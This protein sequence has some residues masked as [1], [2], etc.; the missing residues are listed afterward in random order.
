MAGRDRGRMIP[1]PENLRAWS[2][3]ET[4]SEGK[5]LEFGQESGVTRP[6][7]AR[8]RLLGRQGDDRETDSIHRDHAAARRRALCGRRQRGRRVPGR[9]AHRRCARQPRQR[10]RLVP[11]RRSILRRGRDRRRRLSHPGR[12]LSERAGVSARRA[13]ARRVPRRGERSDRGAG[14]G[15]V[16][17]GRERGRLHHTRRSVGERSAARR[18]AARPSRPAS[19]TTPR[20]AAT[21]IGCG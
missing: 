8:I 18:G 6:A 3:Q 12:V 1:E 11:R 5:E 2:Q 19:A 17:P 20:D 9:M 15:A 4:P 10:Q 16:L 21:P 7:R 14:G 13:R